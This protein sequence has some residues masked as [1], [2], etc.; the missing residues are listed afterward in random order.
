MNK[1]I[2]TNNSKGK[3][4]ITVVKPKQQPNKVHHKEYPKITFDPTDYDFCN[5]KEKWLVERSITQNQ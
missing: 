1:I 4:I 2:V 3:R 5:K